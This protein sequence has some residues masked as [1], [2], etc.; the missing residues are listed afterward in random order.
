[1]GVMAGPCCQRL[2]AGPSG[3]SSISRDGEIRG[4]AGGLLDSGGKGTRRDAERLLYKGPP[5]AL[6]TQGGSFTGSLVRRPVASHYQ[7]I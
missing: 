7:P 5:D 6:A 3:D 2:T 1:M 4:S